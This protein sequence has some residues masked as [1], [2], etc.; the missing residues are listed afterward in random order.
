M[1]VDQPEEQDFKIVL[2]GQVWTIISF[3]CFHDEEMA[4]T[5]Q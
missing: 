1:A 4:E 2:A 3:K 5:A